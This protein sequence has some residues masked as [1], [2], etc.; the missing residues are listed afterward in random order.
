MIMTMRW[1][2]ENN[3]SVSLKQIRQ[4]PNI[5]GIV[6]GLHS[7]PVGEIWPLKDIKEL[8]DQIDSN[9]LTL[10]VIESV[11]VH[12]EIKLGSDKRDY[13][14]D[15]YIETLNNLSKIGIKVVCYNFMPVFDWTRSSLYKEL[16][17][18][19][20]TLEYD[21]DAISKIDP[22]NIAKYMLEEANDFTFPGWEPERMATLKESFERYKNITE[23]DLRDN[24]KYFLTRIIPHCETLDI[25][26]AIH[27]DDPP[28]HIF[29]LPRI[30]KNLD[31]FKKNMSLV[32]SKF[33]G[34][35]LCTGCLGANVNNDIPKMIRVLG[36]MGRIHFAHIRNIK[37]SNSRSFHEV[38]HYSEDG[39]LDMYEIVKA[40]YDI[41]FDSYVRPDHG[42]MIWNE[43]A[44]PGYGLY[45]RA[46][47]ITYIN[48]LL[49]SL[50][51]T[52]KIELA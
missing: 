47:G 17:D 42:R 15:N 45:D 41:G 4:I 38:S 3:D 23:D 25:K 24:L 39:N 22:D 34:I 51:K 28:W 35:T 19:S 7:I 32:D 46:L 30:A 33:N 16:N 11:N 8:K 10:E 48:G 2:G 9:G 13:F 29:G 21:E 40:F 5:K 43:N 49:E 37:F 31:D 14:I 26:M 44:R 27:P 12:E 20:C 6:G 52:K 1:Y 36:A 18:G 50:V